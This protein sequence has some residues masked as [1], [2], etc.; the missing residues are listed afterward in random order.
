MSQAELKSLGHVKKP[1]SKVIREMCNSCVGADPSGTR[2]NEVTLCQ[3]TGCPLWAYRMGK[4]PFSTRGAI[5]D[6]QKKIVAERLT[7][8]RNAKK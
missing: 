2:N 5:S 6:E 7:N 1:L 8:A 4:S 3:A